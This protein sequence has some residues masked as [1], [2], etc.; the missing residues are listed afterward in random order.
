LFRELFRGFFLIATAIVQVVTAKAIIAAEGV[1][2]RMAGEGE[3]FGFWDWLGLGEG[4][5]E[6]LGVG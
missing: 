6:G 1:I 2:S 5:V 4:D 3:L